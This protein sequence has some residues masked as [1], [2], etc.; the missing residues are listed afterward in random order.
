MFGWK[1]GERKKGM[2]SA[3]NLNLS[4]GYFR[5]YIFFMDLLLDLLWL[6]VVGLRG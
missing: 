5:E 4:G 3:G 1:I 6:L 2:R